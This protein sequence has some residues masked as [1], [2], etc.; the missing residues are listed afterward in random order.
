MTIQELKTIEPKT[1]YE[2]EA[3]G[4]KYIVEDKLSIQRFLEADKIELALYGLDF[5]R[6]KATLASVY[7][8]L[9][10]NNSEKMVKF[11][12]A[13]RKVQSLMN[14][15]ETNFELNEHPILRYSALFINHEKEDR[16]TITDEDIEQKIKD[17]QEAGLTLTGFLLFVLH[18]MPSAQ[19]IYTKL[20]QE[21]EPAGK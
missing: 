5:K 4:K 10:G 7:N 17:W 2:F 11:A 1:G 15:H 9:N 6:I 18:K 20:L 8:D 16:R 19:D 21:S 3:N 12:D 13:A 14:Q